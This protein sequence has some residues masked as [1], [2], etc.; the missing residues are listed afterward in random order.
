MDCFSRGGM[1]TEEEVLAAISGLNNDK[2]PGPDG[3]PIAFWSFSWDFVKDEVM[4]F[5]KDF[6][7]NDQ[8]VKSLN[9]TFLVL[10]PKGSTVEDL[11]DLRPISL[12]GS[13]Y[14]IFIESA[15]QHNQKCYEVD[16][17]PVSECVCRREANS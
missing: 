16:Y 15:G 1:F 2:A 14:K 7:Q 8:F 11:K 3:F 6:F 17:L 9:A 13:L 4:G 10:V 12:V 5:F